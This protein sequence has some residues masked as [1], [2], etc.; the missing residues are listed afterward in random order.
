MLE[1]AST[2]SSVGCDNTLFGE[3]REPGSSLNVGFQIDQTLGSKE[4]K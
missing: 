3:F 2:I 1:S 4:G